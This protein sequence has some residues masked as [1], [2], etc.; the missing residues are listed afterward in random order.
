MFVCYSRSF[1]AK[2]LCVWYIGFKLNMSL[3]TLSSSHICTRDLLY[4]LEMRYF[5]TYNTC[6]ALKMISN[7]NYIN[8]KLVDLAMSHPTLVVMQGRHQRGCVGGDKVE[9][10]YQYQSRDTNPGIVV[11]NKI[12]NKVVLNKIINKLYLYVWQ[13][14]VIHGCTNSRQKQQQWKEAA[15]RILNHSQWFG[16]QG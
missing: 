11:L 6:L 4:R 13:R 3:H 10:R 5:K 1:L 7:E 12:I 16:I 2:Y 9:L 14:Q 8:N 15:T